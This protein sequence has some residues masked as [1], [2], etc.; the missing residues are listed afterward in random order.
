MPSRIALRGEGWEAE[1]FENVFLCLCAPSNL[2]PDYAVGVGE[3]DPLDEP[4]QDV[5]IL[6]AALENEGARKHPVLEI[7][8]PTRG[9]GPHCVPRIT[10]AKAAK[11]VMFC[12]LE[13]NDF[14]FVRTLLEMSAISAMKNSGH[15]STACCK[16][17]QPPAN[18]SRYCKIPALAFGLWR[19][20]ILFHNHIPLPM[21]AA[22]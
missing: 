8:F 7:A 12:F 5:A 20:W 6:G 14:S 17:L 15:F 2:R 1:G 11:I 10:K 9:L 19:S 3:V 18:F 16:V 13:F 22:M 21:L 4:R